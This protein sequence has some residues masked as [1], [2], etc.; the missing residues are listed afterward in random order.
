MAFVEDRS[1][2]AR[3]SQPADVVIRLGVLDE[4]IADIR[5]AKGGAAKPL[6]VFIHGG[7]WRPQIDRTHAGVPSAAI[8]EA[9]WTVATIEYRRTPGRPDDT[10]VDIDLAISQLPNQVKK[11][12]GRMIVMG[13]SA[14]GHLTLLAATRA[15]AALIGVI[16]L[17]PVADLQ[18]ADAQ[19]LGA[20]AARAFLGVPAQQR[21]DLDP[22]LLDT[23]SCNVSIVHGVQ[24]EIAPIAMSENYLLR[25]PKTRLIKVNDCGHFAVIDPLS[26]A[27]P[28]VIEELTRLSA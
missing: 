5:Y 27:W 26:N 15:S 18:Y 13:H 11:Q 10:I 14:G 20:G 24:D 16:A 2:L 19:S 25:H 3:S 1:V 7:F 9:G 17:G 22:T 8:A 21:K 6:V 23:Q 4:Q 12:D 28:C